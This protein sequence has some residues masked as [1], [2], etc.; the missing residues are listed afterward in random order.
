MNAEPEPGVPLGSRQARDPAH[1]TCFQ[2][3]VSLTGYSDSV[4]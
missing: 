3:G 2:A 1:T 4:G